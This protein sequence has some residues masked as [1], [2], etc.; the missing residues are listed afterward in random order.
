M[1]V[2]RNHVPD[3]ALVHD[4]RIRIRLH[5]LEVEDLVD[6][7]VLVVT[8][9]ER[10]TD[11]T[12]SGEQAGLRQTVAGMDRI[13]NLIPMLTNFDQC[14]REKNK[15]ISSF[16]G[17]AV[18]GLHHSLRQRT[19]ASSGQSSTHD[20]FLHRKE[21]GDLPPAERRWSHQV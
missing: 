12:G 11:T 18:I 5:V 21:P 9:A 14:R 20:R 15:R 6:V 16:K 2:C 1:D 4:R 10:F 3:G 7:L 8:D 19:T 17:K 13:F